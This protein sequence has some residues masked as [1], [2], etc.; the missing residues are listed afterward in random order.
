MYW[1]IYTT[2]DNKYIGK[3]I[4]LTQLDALYLAKEKYYIADGTAFKAI[5]NKLTIEGYL[6][7]EH[8]YEDADD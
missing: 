7:V 6:I 3:V 2:D 5:G 1:Y 8:Q 4:A